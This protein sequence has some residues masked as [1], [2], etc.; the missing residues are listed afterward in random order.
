MMP[1]KSISE[2]RKEACKTYLEQTKLLVTLA[3]A[4]LFA[5]AGLVALLK[6]RTAAGAKYEHIGW[7]IS[8]EVLFVISVLSGYVAL[9]SLAGS[10]DREEFDVYRSSVRYA[11]LTQF[12]AYLAGLVIFVCIATSLVT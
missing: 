4:F 6:D 9:G 11:S 7:L 2:G 10:Q 1:S 12:A 5:P 3:S 8:A